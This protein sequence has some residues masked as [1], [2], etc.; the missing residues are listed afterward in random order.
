[1][2]NRNS[3][4]SRGQVAELNRIAAE[5][6]GILKPEDVVNAAR[7]KS[8][9]L[10]NCFEWSDTAAAREWRIHQARNLIRVVVTTV[11]IHG[12]DTPCRVFVSLT[13]DRQE[14]G[15]GYR[16]I[17]TVLSD[18]E[19]RAQLLADAKAEMTLFVQKYGRLKE[20]ARVVDAI[21]AALG[22]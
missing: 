1:M 12:H 8:S 9:P 6:D 16:Q 17:V 14:E 4:P 15:G 21:R 19:M 13:P 11:P 5:N 20:L 3:K 2:R 10:H 18:T 22:E 7:P